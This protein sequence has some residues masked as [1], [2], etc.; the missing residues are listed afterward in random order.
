MSQCSAVT[1]TAKGSVA[2]V[3]PL[4]WRSSRLQRPNTGRIGMLNFKG[5][6]FPIDVILV[7][8]RW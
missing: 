1:A 2:L 8:M 7:C 6:R 5:T 3:K 4:A